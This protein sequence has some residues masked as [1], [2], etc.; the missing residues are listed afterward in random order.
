MDVDSFEP[1]VIVTATGADGQSEFVSDGP[2]TSRSVTPISTVCNIWKISELP[3]PPD[4]LEVFAEPFEFLA[5]ER[6]V[7]VLQASLRPDSE[8]ANDPEAHAR[9]FA[10]RGQ[11]HADRSG[12][13]VQGFHQTYSIDI[14]TLISGELV[15]LMDTGEK[16]LRPG[17][18]LVQRG[19]SHAWSNRGTVP[20]VFTLTMVRS[21]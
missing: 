11:R 13:R 3:A 9:A 8:W 6:G 18:T 7:K 10:M 1:R 16:V 12:G 17:D 20:A 21:G 2:V 4:T 14:V 5:P 15:A 19:T